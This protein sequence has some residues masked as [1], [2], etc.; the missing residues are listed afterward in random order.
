MPN[1][2]HPGAEIWRSQMAAITKVLARA[3]PVTGDRNRH[4][5]TACTVV[6]RRLAGI[7][8]A[9]DLRRGSQPRL[10][11]AAFP[12]PDTLLRARDF[13]TGLTL[14]MLRRPPFAIMSASV[15]LSST[16]EIASRTFVIIRRTLQA[17]T[18][19]QS[20]HG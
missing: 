1:R 20:R 17:L 5:R 11:L 16:S 14:A 8:A 10:F 4:S 12:V 13:R 3:F 6:R 15:T 18:L 7:A 2:F 9:D 19:L